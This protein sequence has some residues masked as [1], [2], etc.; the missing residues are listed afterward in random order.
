LRHLQHPTHEHG[1]VVDDGHELRDADLGIAQHLLKSRD[2]LRHA[3]QRKLRVGFDA[4]KILLERRRIVCDDVLD[5]RG[6]KRHSRHVYSF[7]RPTRP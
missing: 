2:D 3:G 7:S 5:R 4:G 1:L 6:S